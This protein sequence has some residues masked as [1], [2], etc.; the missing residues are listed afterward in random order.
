MN[1]ELWWVHKPMGK[2]KNKIA[3]G[4]LKTRRLKSLLGKQNS[5][6]SSAVEDDEL[7]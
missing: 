3:A 1:L 5:H 6:Q 7:K 2:G 4:K